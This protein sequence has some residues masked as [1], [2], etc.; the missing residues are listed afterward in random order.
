[1]APAGSSLNGPRGEGGGGSTV[2]GGLTP[3]RQLR[4]GQHMH[5]DY[6]GMHSI[7]I[8]RV[9]AGV[10]LVHEPVGVGTIS[11]EEGS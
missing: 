8:R 3:C 6:L 4:G 7:N 11:G 2:S 9:S 1:M 5:L 10:L